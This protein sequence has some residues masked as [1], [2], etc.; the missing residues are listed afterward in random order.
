MSTR[1]RHWQHVEH[2]LGTE[3]LPEMVG[4][5]AG[6]KEAAVPSMWRKTWT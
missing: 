3:Q 2:R 4:T 6:P 1:L 5:T